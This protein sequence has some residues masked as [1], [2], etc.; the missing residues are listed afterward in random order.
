MGISPVVIKPEMLCSINLGRRVGQI[1]E[2]II[3]AS[4]DFN[5]FVIVELPKEY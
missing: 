3:S 1:I 4:I 5:Q 2:L